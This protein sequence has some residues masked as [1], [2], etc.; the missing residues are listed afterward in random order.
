M[1]VATVVLISVSAFP[2]T[3]PAVTDPAPTCTSH[4]ASDF[5][6]DGF[7]DV[8]ASE[9]NRTI[10]KV[11]S[12]GAVRILYGGPTGLVVT[13]TDQY[14]DQNSPGIVGAPSR[15]DLFGLE[16]ATGDFNGDCHA[17]LAIGTPGENDVTILYGSA[18]GL[19]TIGAG[20]LVGE[21]P[22]SSFGWDLVAGDFN[23][24]G[25]DDLA[26]GAPGAADAGALGS[27][28]VGISY[29]GA[30]GLQ[31]PSTWI[32]Q[33]TTGVP[34]VPETGDGFGTSLAAGAFTGDGVTDLAVG[35]PC[36]DNGSIS[37]G[38]SVTVLPS[39]AVGG[40]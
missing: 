6:G 1:F 5:N 31:A 23:G 24:D 8:A 10:G 38:G 39:S 20:H 34:G 14:F 7:A 25:V 32:D 16:L 19:S 2:V 3:A 37:D 11:T 40:L 21:Q 4:V 12:A 17:D 9:P 29:G 15:N 30:S 33:S 36:E 13:G 35:V 22:K 28:E 26:V 27:G 18:T